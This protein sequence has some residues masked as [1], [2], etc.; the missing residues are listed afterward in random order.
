MLSTGTLKSVNNDW[1]INSNGT[2]VFKNGTIGGWTIGENDIYDGD[3]KNNANIRLS[4]DN[5]TNTGKIIAKAGT[6]GGWTINKNSISSG[7]LTLNKNGQIEAS[8]YTI[9]SSGI[10]NIR[11]TSTGMSGSAG[12]GGG[13]GIGNNVPVYD[14]G[15]ESL[16]TLTKFVE[17]LTV[18]KLTVNASFEFGGYKVAWRDFNVVLNVT[19]STTTNEVMIGIDANN[20]PITTTLKYINQINVIRKKLFLLTND[21]SNPDTKIVQ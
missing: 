15:G 2:V 18:N 8:N 10:S 9:T 16:G 4:F 6:I 7:G 21:P 3:S 20:N 19:G 1:A 12:S 17:D 11:L 14:G 5:D 13:G